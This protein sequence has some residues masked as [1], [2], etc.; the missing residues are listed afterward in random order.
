LRC[1]KDTGLSL[2]VPMG[3]T[4]GCPTAYY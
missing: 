3:R 1:L 4:I 2:Y